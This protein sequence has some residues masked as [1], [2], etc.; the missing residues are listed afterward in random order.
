MRLIKAH[1]DYSA[2]SPKPFQLANSDYSPFRILTL[3][4]ILQ[5][6]AS[7]LVLISGAAED[8]ALRRKLPV[9]QN[10]IAYKGKAIAMSNLRMRDPK[11]MTNDGA[12]TAVCALAGWE[13]L[14]GTPEVY[15]I[16]MDG[17]CQLLKVRGGLKELQISN[18]L[19]TSLISWYVVMVLQLFVFHHSSLTSVPGTTTRA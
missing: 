1:V 14:F 15:R 13:L 5:D 2:F 7:F 3:R 16:H 12:I 8:L 6:P 18:P 9:P 4:V 19:L 10:A 17:L 11:R